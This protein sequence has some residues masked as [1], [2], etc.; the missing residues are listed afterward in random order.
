MNGLIKSFNNLT[1]MNLKIFLKNLGFVTILV[2]V[3]RF[4]YLTI[5]Q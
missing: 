3:L 2:M 1:F 4:L 5:R